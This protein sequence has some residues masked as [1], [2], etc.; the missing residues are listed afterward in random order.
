MTDDADLFRTI[1]ERLFTAVIGDVMDGAALT[2]QFL[3][4]EIRALRP[5]MVVAG[6]A[7]PVLEAD[8]AGDAVAHTGGA[9][10][11]GLM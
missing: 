7:M 2:R 9:D 5:E 10:P 8:C 6:R 4:S 3:P 1:R 11:F